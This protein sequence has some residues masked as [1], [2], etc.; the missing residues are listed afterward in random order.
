MDFKCRIEIERQ[1]LYQLVGSYA[2]LDPRSLMKSQEF[3]SI[4]NQYNELIKKEKPT[5]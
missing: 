5:A 2:L 3:D 1:Q 4:L